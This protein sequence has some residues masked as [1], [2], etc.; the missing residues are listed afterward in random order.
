MGRRFSSDEAAD[1]ESSAGQ[2]FSASVQEQVRYLASQSGIGPG[3][4]VLMCGVVDAGL[5][6]ALTEL[7]LLVTC[8]SDDSELADNIQCSVPEAD[9]CEGGTP[10]EQFDNEASGFDM[11]VVA[12]PAKQACESLLGRSPL[13]ELASRFACL[14]PGGSLV[15][16]GQTGQDCGIAATHSLSCCLRQ[17]SLF[18]GKRS[19]NRSG[20]QSRLRFASRR[21]QF[22]LAVQVPEQRMSPFEWD[23]LAM[24]GVRRL[25]PEC[26]RTVGA[27]HDIRRAA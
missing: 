12:V 16:L 18:P 21:G 14:R 6:R 3:S 22:A 23:V 2:D 4:R 11:V 26:C 7:G 8:V 5:T 25:P 24:E 15:M 10:R 20:G 27:A 17:V 13:I 19:I 9:C 1:F